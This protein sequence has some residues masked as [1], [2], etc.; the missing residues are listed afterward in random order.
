MNLHEYQSKQLFSD[1]GIPVLKGG[2]ASTPDQARKIAEDLKVDTWV[3]KAQVHAGGRGK[4]GGVKI[5]KSIDEVQSIATS[6]LGSRLITKQTD[7]KGL[8]IDSV[9]IESGTSIASEYYLS[10]LIDRAQESW[11]FI[12]SSEGGMDIETVADVSP[13]KIIRYTIDLKDGLKETELSTMADSLG[14]KNNAV[15][16]FIDITTKLFSLAVT[17][18]SDLI[19]INPLILDERNHL[20]ALDSKMSIDSNAL[21]RQEDLCLMKDPNQEDKL[22]VKASENDLS[23]VSLDGEI[24]CMVNGAGLA[25]ATMDIIKLYG[26]E[27]ANFLDVGGGASKEKVAAAFKL[28]LSD[29]NVK[30]ILINIFGGIIRC[31]MIAEGIISAAKETNL[32]L[33]VIVRFQGTNAELGRKVINNSKLNIIAA[34]TLNDAA[35]KAVESIKI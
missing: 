11:T 5:T 18:D 23:Y 17:K 12:G 26:K 22:E 28:I 7:D 34:D 4:A 25:M 20:I 21:F 30:G 2:V 27:P 31:D 15:A 24:A 9:Y 10:L 1:V 8:P 35:K 13:E 16:E 29:K 33:P 3:I 19:E 14:L 6:M 32:K